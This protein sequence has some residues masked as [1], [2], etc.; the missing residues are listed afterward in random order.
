MPT[1]VLSTPRA[2][3]QIKSLARKAAKIFDDFLDDMAAEGC[4]ALSY[5]LSGEP[6]VSHVCVKHLRGSL[7]VVVAFESPRKAW[8]LLVG[9][10]DS[11]TPWRRYLIARRNSGR[12]VRGDPSDEHLAP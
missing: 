5:R 12:P 6:P 2:D 8:I 10:H 7:R 9:P 1:E 4:Q 3:Q 11:A